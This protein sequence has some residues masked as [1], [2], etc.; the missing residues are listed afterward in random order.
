[1]IISVENKKTDIFDFIGG[2]KRTILQT[3][4]T[5]KINLDVMRDEVKVVEE[6]HNVMCK[7]KKEI[8]EL[9]KK[10]NSERKDAANCDCKNNESQIENLKE[11][12]KYLS[13]QVKELSRLNCEKE[14]EIRFLESEKKKLYNELQLEKAINRRLRNTIKNIS[15]EKLC[16][17][18]DVP[19]FIDN[20][21]IPSDAIIPN[22][23]IAGMIFER[24]RF[25]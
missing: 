18:N 6:M 19:T 25:L 7:Q 8:D 14:D 5:L 23:L 9:K 11:R 15:E 12:N 4:E 16:K 3:E 21:Y 22:E 20:A 24:P 2:L 17:K 1:M 10:L 13:E